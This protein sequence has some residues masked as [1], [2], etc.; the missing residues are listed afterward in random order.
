MDTLL[1]ITILCRVADWLWLAI[2]TQND[3]LN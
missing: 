3:T 1:A 2:R